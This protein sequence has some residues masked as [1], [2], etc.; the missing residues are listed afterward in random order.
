MAIYI[1]K[2]PAEADNLLKYA[3][4]IRELHSNHGDLTWR[5]YDE[6]FRRLRQSHHPPI[7]ELYTKAG[8]RRNNVQSAVT[9]Q[10][11]GRCYGDNNSHNRP[12]RNKVCFAYNRGETCP[13][14]CR[15]RHNC[16][17]C[18]AASHP[19]TKCFKLLRQRPITHAKKPNTPNSS[20][21]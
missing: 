18:G 5:Q 3:A 2:C 21:A 6:G 16:Q 1:L 12:F 11:G 7:D 15:F 17:V 13:N 14:P 19:N 20:T 10:A 4:T 9:S 8:N